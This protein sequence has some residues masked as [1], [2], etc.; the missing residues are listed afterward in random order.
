MVQGSASDIIKLAML[1]VEDALAEQK[2]RGIELLLQIH[3]EL[4]YDVAVDNVGDSGF[5]PLQ[6]ATFEGIEPEQ[7]EGR[8]HDSSSTPLAD[9]KVLTFAKLLQN[10]MEIQVASSLNFRIPLVVNI[11][12][13]NTWGNME[14]LVT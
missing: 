11:S 13:G 2:A 9:K 12:C 10:C 14:K 3:D 1:S 6:K 4:I 5:L 8:G 7:E